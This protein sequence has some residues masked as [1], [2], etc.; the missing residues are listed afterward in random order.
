[1]FSWF[2]GANDVPGNQTAKNVIEGTVAATAGTVG[3]TAEAATKL[4]EGT[5]E[6]VAQ[7]AE[8]A[9][10]KIG[11]AAVLESGDVGSV[12]ITE[13][14]KIAVSG[15]KGFGEGGEIFARELI[16]HALI[17]SEKLG[18]AAFKITETAG[19]ALTS[20]PVQDAVKGAVERTAQAG[21]LTVEDAALIAA[22]AAKYG[23]KALLAM[24]AGASG[25]GR[26]RRRSSRRHTK[27]RHLKRRTAKHR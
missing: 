20:K 9:G 4:T 25:G 2:T 5:A 17:A 12:A 8:G 7:Q 15:L 6:G 14:G 26:R 1:M 22:V 13:S 16:K 27:R 21:F 18:V 10:E 11:A 24:L 3:Y 23:E 19:E